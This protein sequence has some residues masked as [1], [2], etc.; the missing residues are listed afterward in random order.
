[1]LARKGSFETIEDVNNWINQCASIIKSHR[2]KDTVKVDL[3]QLGWLS[4][5]GCAVLISTLDFFNQN[6]CLD[7]AIPENGEIIGYMERMNFFKVCRKEI[8]DQFES[9][10]DMERYYNRNRNNKENN[11]FEITKFTD[12]DDVDIF[13]N[14]IM[15]ILR[16]KSL[17][18]DRVSDIANIF[19]ELGNNA[20]EHAECSPYS[21]IQHY[22]ASS[23]VSIAIC[24]TGLGIYN[25]L[26]HTFSPFLTSHAVIKKA[27]LTTASSRVNE[28]RGK[29]LIDVTS[30]A[31]NFKN[32]NFYLRTHNSAYI[33][34]EDNLVLISQDE[35]FYG[36]YFYLTIQV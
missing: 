25:S 35:F 34:K 30:R 11:L 26:K 16:D 19:S 2:T 29:G 8:S 6:F 23:T 10:T 7:I 32:V 5:A 21:C 20:L 36:T 13:Y 3:S 9:K 1:M 33:I 12:P 28:N 14:S 4:P 31:Y 17:P 27:I 22:E 18:R 15:K 24:D